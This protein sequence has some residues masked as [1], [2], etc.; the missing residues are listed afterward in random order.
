MAYLW[1]DAWQ[2]SQERHHLLRWRAVAI[3]V[4]RTLQLTPI[5]ATS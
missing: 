3:K 5:R 4:Y 1:D 2:P